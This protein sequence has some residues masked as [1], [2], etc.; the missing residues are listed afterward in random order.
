M[1]DAGFDPVRT[2][3]DLLARWDSA[4]RDSGA[5][6]DGEFRVWLMRTMPELLDAM[7]P[8]LDN[9]A[10]H[11]T[12]VAA[13]VERCTALGRWDDAITL[14][15]W[16]TDEY[17]PRGGT[18]SWNTILGSVALCARVGQD[19]HLHGRAIGLLTRVARAAP[20]DGG[21]EVDR[22][23]CKAL[24]DLSVLYTVGRTADDI[25]HRTQ[26][27]IDVCDE[28]IARWG[29][30]GDNWLRST[31]AGA[32]L[33]K[34]TSLLEFGD[35]PAARDE[36]RRVVGTFAG[37]DGEEVGSRVSIAR[38]ALD[39]LDN[40]RF[41]EPE[42]TVAYAE[43]RRRRFRREFRFG[44]GAESRERLRAA[45]LLH[46]AT[47]AFV[48]HATCFG[49]PWVLLL[50]NF[51]LLER[52][53]VTDSPPAWADPHGE[54]EVYARAIH[55][56][57]GLDLVNRLVDLTDVVQVANTGAA[58]LE[59]DGETLSV[60]G[61][62]RSPRLLYLP[63]TSWLPH[64]RLLIGLAE[65]IVV[66][67]HEKTPP[68]AQ[69]LDAIRELGRVEDAVVL[70]ESRQG[71]RAA[72]PGFTPSSARP[73]PLLPDD[74]A[75]EGFS[76]VTP[77]DGRGSGGTP[78]ARDLIRSVTVVGELGDD[79]AVAGFLDIIRDER[80]REVDAEHAPLLRDT[81]KAVADARNRPAAERVARLQQRIERLRRDDRTWHPL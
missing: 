69:E 18:R 28:I 47:A 24:T 79:H 37:D 75:L 46:H 50:R 42:F 40:A 49:E 38:H 5:R 21:I 78:S 51:D 17:V 35:E 48:R 16:L 6:G 62:R 26:A 23:T 22:A 55:F 80:A 60:H 20:A 43:A 29:A 14:S 25:A 64:V 30:S 19:P 9:E 15:E 70:L 12:G 81:L 13:T 1:E 52:A 67:A 77:V 68:L 2:A 53:V 54:E 74:P 4:R 59:I 3:D 45:G 31:V 66:W 8:G 44:A 73:V 71:T 58:A 39:A 34:A 10:A 63:G 27:S 65:R 36:Y 61:R 41:P 72:L 32:M 11:W 57:D 56:A 33:N 76:V 7:G